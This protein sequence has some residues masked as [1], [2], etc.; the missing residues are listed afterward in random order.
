[1]AKKLSGS[2]TAGFLKAF[3]PTIGDP[4]TAFPPSMQR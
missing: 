1:L 4:A 2:F 3:A